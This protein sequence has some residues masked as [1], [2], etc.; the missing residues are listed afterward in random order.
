MSSPKTF[1][2]PC[3]YHKVVYAVVFIV[4]ML[5]YIIMFSCPNHRK[6]QQHTL[7]KCVTRL[8]HIH[9]FTTYFASHRVNEVWSFT[10]DVAFYFVLFAICSEKCIA[11]DDIFTKHTVFIARFTYIR[12]LVNFCLYGKQLTVE[13]GKFLLIWL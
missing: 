5:C 6:V 10:I 3:N 2:I 4:E 7:I 9:R 12:F 8:S 11:S 13:S 1:S